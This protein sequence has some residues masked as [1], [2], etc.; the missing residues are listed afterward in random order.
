MATPITTTDRFVC[1]VCDEEIILPTDVV[2]DEIVYCP[3]CS[4][5]Y[6]ITAIVRNGDTIVSAQAELLEIEEDRGE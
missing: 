2:E 3:T 1:T 4:T 5:P 6:Q